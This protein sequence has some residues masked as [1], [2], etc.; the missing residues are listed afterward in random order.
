MKLNVLIWVLFLSI[1]IGCAEKQISL[2]PEVQIK[3]DKIQ[4]NKLKS[5]KY[6][7]SRCT[8]FCNRQ[9]KDLIKINICYN[10]IE[11]HFDVKYLCGENN[12]N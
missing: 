8:N 7:I 3:C 11:D 5:I 6:I 4:T 10:R 1:L 9:N 12:E 2:L